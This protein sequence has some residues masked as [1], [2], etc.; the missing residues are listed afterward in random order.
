MNR[1]LA[2]D[3]GGLFILQPARAIFLPLVARP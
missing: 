3:E 1:W 2:F